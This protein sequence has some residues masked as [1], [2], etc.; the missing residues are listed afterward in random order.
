L[1]AFK[2]Q[3]GHTLGATAALE[4]ALLLSALKQGGSSDYQGQEI[5]FSECAASQKG[6]F[7][8]LANQFGFGGSNTSLVWQWQP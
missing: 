3:I 5:R 7:F 1:M 6:G 8:C 2:P 4:T